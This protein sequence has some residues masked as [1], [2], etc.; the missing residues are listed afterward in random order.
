[1]VYLKFQREQ[2]LRVLTM[3]KNTKFFN[4]MRW[5]MLTKLRVAS[6]S[7]YTSSHC[8]IHLKLTYGAVCQLYPNKTG[9][10]KN[11]RKCIKLTTNSNPVL[12]IVLVFYGCIANYHKLSSLRHHPL[13][14]SRFGRSESWVVLAVLSAGRIR[15]PKSAGQAS[16]LK[17][18]DKNLLPSFLSLLAGFRSSGM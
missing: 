4:Y 13:R 7:Q 3:R 17:V 11:S 10:R 6:I 8:A 9:R 16:Y 2:I 15:R 14:I 1:M 5:W 12:S 18:L